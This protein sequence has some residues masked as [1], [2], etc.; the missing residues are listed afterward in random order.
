MPDVYF[1]SYHR[2]NVRTIDEWLSLLK[3]DD[4]LDDDLDMDTLGLYPV[5]GTALLY[6]E[7]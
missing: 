1:H 3:E 6:E 4:D 7:T 5:Q 2:N